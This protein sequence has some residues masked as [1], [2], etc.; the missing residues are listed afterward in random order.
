VAIHRKVPDHAHPGGPKL[1]VTMP[2]FS[3]VPNDGLAQL[4]LDAW[5]NVPF[6]N[7]GGPPNLKDG[8]M[9]RE[10]AGP[11]KGLPTTRAVQLAT[12]RVNTLGRFNLQ[13]AVVI[14]EEEHDNNYT[15]QDDNEIVFVLPNDGRIVAGGARL[16]DTAKLLMACTP[17]GI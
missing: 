7:P 12:E 11:K 13:R 1:D 4:I 17:N 6:S 10:P 8:L 9:E 5:A 14:S 2:T 15:M 16:L 3:Y